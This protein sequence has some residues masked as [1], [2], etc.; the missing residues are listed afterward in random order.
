MDLKS[1]ED[2]EEEYMNRKYYAEK[3]RLQNQLMEKKQYETN[4]QRLDQLYKGHCH[5]LVLE[6]LAEQSEKVNE[7]HE[8]YKRIREYSKIV[9]EEFKPRARSGN[10]MESDYG[11]IESSQ[12]PQTERGRRVVKDRYLKG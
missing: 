1:L 11:S 10:D 8:K 4:K 7:A 5:S 6:E 12:M 9:K 2:F 3:Q